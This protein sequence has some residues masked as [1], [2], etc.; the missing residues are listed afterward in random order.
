MIEVTDAEP[1]LVELQP[2]DAGQLVVVH[3]PIPLVQI[4]GTSTA[5]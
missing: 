5:S 2:V 4:G 1:N 3:A